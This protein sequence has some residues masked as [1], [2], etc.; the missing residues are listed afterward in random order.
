[1]QPGEVDQ[2]VVGYLAIVD[3]E[4]LLRFRVR[5]LVAIGAGRGHEPELVAHRL[6]VEHRGEPEKLCESLCSTGT[7]T[8]SR[9]RSVR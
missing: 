8:R 3:A 9:P 7:S 1:V 6:V 2:R 4:R 5:H